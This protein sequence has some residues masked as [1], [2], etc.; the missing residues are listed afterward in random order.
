M[1]MVKW[2]G[3]EVQVRRGVRKVVWLLSLL[4]SPCALTQIAN[5]QVFQTDAAKTPLP[6]PVGSAELQLCNLSYLYSATTTSSFDP[7]GAIV[8]LPIV[9]GQYYSPPAFPQFVDG[10]EVTLSGLFK[11]RKE[12]IDPVADAKTAPGHFFPGCGFTAELVLRGGA[13]KSGLGW[14]NVTPGNTAPPAA[15][16]IYPLVPGD[17]AYLNATR[18]NFA[19][20]AWDNRTPYNLSVLA[21]TPMSFSSGAIQSDPHYK[22]GEIAFAL[23]GQPSGQCTQNKYSL[24]E[25]NIKNASGIPWVTALIYKSTVDPSAIYLAFEDLPMSPSDWHQA[26]SSSSYTNDGDFND[27]VFFISGLGPTSTCPDPACKAVACDPGMVCSSGACVPAASGGAGAGGTGAGGASN[28]AASSG[29]AGKGGSHSASNGGQSFAGAAD[30][31]DGN[32]EASNAGS[33]GD[34]DATAGAAGSNSDGNGGSANGGEAGT[35]EMGGTGGNADPVSKSG[36]SCRIGSK[37]AN[38]DQLLW[39]ALGVAGLS[40]RWRKRR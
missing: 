32:L 11:W 38:R 29:S 6:Q 2:S 17:P 40:R 16:E 3:D 13:C 4:G 8:P 9:Y 18:D 12:Q 10:D 27:F 14:Y 23:V 36:C 21:W 15:S 33:A 24:Y 34:S 7:S 5:A 1:K 35:T 30:A 22:G 26:G 28:G 39:L 20:L 37:A 31:G 19:P 25:H